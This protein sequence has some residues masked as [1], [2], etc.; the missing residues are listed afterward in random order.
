MNKLNRN[1]KKK[2]S[3]NLYERALDQ[4]A[5]HLNPYTFYIALPVYQLQI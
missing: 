5:R 1:A 4:N 2:R 3:L